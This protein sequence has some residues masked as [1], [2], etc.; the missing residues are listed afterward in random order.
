MSQEART[1]TTS[2][3]H[4][5][6]AIFPQPDKLDKAHS[7]IRLTVVPR[8]R[9]LQWT[10]NNIAR[11]QMQYKTEYVLCCILS[12]YRIS[13]SCSLT[14]LF[15]CCLLPVIRLRKFLRNISKALGSMPTKRKRTRW[16]LPMLNLQLKPSPNRKSRSKPLAVSEMNRPAFDNVCHLSHS[17]EPEP[18]N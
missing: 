2:I 18:N 1:L 5:S 7:T 14:G 4:W 8:S 17:L 11:M 10:E 15:S 6:V 9:A 16:Y 13:R 3:T 12:L